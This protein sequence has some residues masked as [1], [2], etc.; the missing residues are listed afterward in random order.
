[1]VR[2]IVISLCVLTFGLLVPVL[3]INATHVWNPDW[4]AH[5]RLHEVWQLITNCLLAGG[6]L[7]LA[8]VRNQVAAASLLALAVIS[9]FL[10]AYLV[11][12][13]YG[14]SM[15]HPNGSELLVGGVNPATAVMLAAA[16]ALA[17]CLWSTARSLPR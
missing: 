1:M 12:G 10:A 3:E 17:G 7:W 16:I 5:A 6:C 4:P 15:V 14:G 9:G 2:K 8:W 11:R 13:A